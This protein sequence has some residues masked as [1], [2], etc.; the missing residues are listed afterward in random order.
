MVTSSQPAAEGLSRRLAYFDDLVPALAAAESSREVAAVSLRGAARFFGARG[1]LL[2]QLAPDGQVLDLFAA[3]V[4]TPDLR[5]AA[6]QAGLGTPGTLSELRRGQLRCQDDEGTLIVTPL[7]IGSDLLGALVL[8]YPR[9]AALTA[10]DLE[11][12]PAVASQCALALVRS[13]LF[14]AEHA[15]RERLGFLV[16]AGTALAGS[17]ELEETLDRLAGLVV[18]QLADWCAIHVEEEPGR[19]RQMALRHR[20]PGSVAAT[21]NLLSKLPLDRSQ[22]YGVGAVLASGR[23]QVLAEVPDDVRVALAA[24]NPSLLRALRGLPLGAGLIVPLSVPGRTLGA[25][26]LIREAG[27]PYSEVDV[28][29][30]EELGKRAGLA[31]DAALAH[32]LVQQAFR[33]RDAAAELADLDRERLTAL[34][35]QLPV[36]VVLADARSGRIRLSNRATHRIWGETFELGTVADYAERLGTRPDGTQLPVEDWPLVR[37]IRDGV[38]SRGER[39]A[40]TRADGRRSYLEISAG[41][42]RDRA[43]QVV[44]GVAVF[45]D[46]SDRVAAEHALAA[47]EQRAQALAHTLQE[48]LLPPA[49]PE[50]DGLDLG[51][52]YRPVGQGIE[53]GGD[54]Y[55]VIG[56]AREDEWAVVIGDVCGKGAP[57]AALTALARHTIRAAAVR[58]RRPSVILRQLNE[59]M[60]RHASERP[61]LTGVYASL[62]R[63]DDD[64]LPY[65][66]TLAVGGHPLPLLLRADGTVNAVGQPGS[67]IGILEDAEFTDEVVPLGHGDVLL[68]FTDG[69]TEARAGQ[70]FF[71]E[72]RLRAAVSGQ[73]GGSAAEVVAG[74]L[75]A[76]DKFSAGRQRDDVALLALRVR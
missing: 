50:I 64:A 61:F 4:V 37:A 30:A 43:G 71:G 35:E 9:G 15:A 32:R 75:A 47:S 22:P 40:L 48:S 31:V 17:L 1:A 51:A 41:P 42:V 70:E 57:A 26:T 65:R 25:I 14:E 73:A 6:E 63:L 29:V 28:E 20:N 68:L 13:R 52:A 21:A 3:A 8:G 53:V 58:A 55:D 7:A 34:L 62:R 12:L 33:Q 76:V 18:P 67:L 46:V 27:P 44:S 60:L 39:V 74:V 19:L 66:L 54:F 59:V 2:A 72:S 5:A 10:N 24:G 36:G 45:S 11:F 38:E 23:G 49:L 56:T 16:D 69:L